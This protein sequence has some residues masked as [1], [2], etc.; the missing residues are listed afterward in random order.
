MGKQ[1]MTV[2]LTGNGNFFY[3]VEVGVQ[4]VFIDSAMTGPDNAITIA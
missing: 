2:K 4:S 3:L 1:A